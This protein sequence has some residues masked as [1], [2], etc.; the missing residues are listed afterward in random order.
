[1]PRAGHICGSLECSAIVE[2]GKRYC[3]A[4]AQPR[5]QQQRSERTES[6]RRTG[7]RRFNSVIRPAVLKRDGF[8]CQLNIDGVC[9]SRGEPLPADQLEIDHIRECAYGG[10]DDLENLRVVCRPCHRRRGRTPV[11]EFLAPAQPR[12]RRKQTPAERP[13]QIPRTIWTHP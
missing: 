12:P 13:V 6:A 8:V 10:S 5:Y 11:E 2:H 3:P 9:A 7:T 1:M 4:H